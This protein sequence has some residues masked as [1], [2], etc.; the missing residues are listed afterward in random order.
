MLVGEL[1]RDHGSMLGMGGKFLFP[2]LPIP[3]MGP[4]L[5]YEYI[6]YK[7]RKFYPITCH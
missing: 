1:L 2:E 7:K 4:T 3:A 6:H 5:T